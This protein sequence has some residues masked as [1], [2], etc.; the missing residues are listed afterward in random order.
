MTAPLFLVEPSDLPQTVSAGEALTVPASVARHAFKSMRLAQGD[1]LDLSDGRGRRLG[2][3]VADPAQG[4]V[5]A[6]EDRREDPPR[7]RL[8][9]IQALA[10]SGRDEQA[11]E[12]ATEIGV[13]VV[14]PWQANRSIVQ[15][16]PGREGK[17][18]LKWAQTIAAATEQS[19]RAFM[20]ELREKVTTRQL[21]RF[22]GQESADG[23]LMVVLHQ[24]A[25]DTWAGIEELVD[26]MTGPASH[27]GGAGDGGD[28]RRS[29]PV[30]WVVVG[31]EGGISEEE[32]AS[33]VAAGAHAAVIGSNIL[34]ASSA[35]PVALALLSRVLGRC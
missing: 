22:I 25:T 2:V 1:S 10:K 35:G 15:W 31:P 7:V 29:A 34:R 23:G 19:R 21:E 8:G 30:V 17:A 9:L 6:V 5:H 12:M 20:P 33:F 32:V 13:D 18:A 16:K 11:V 14:V 27:G 28:E 3:T 4:L 24:D 26:A